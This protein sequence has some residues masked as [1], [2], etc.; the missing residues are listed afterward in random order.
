MNAPLK[1]IPWNEI[2]DECYDKQ[3]C[4]IYDIA[5]VIYTDDRTERAVILHKPNGLYTI[6]VEKLY[7]FDDDELKYGISDLHGYWRTC[8]DVGSI[9]DT[10]ERA[11][12][13]IMADPP[14]KYN[15]LT[16]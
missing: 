14:F 3:L 13:S 7:P 12:N 15:R 16:K 9:F 6:I 4:Y 5:K 8:N 2:V 11:K 1:I 10:E